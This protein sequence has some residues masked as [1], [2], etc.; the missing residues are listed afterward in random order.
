LTSGSVRQGIAMW[1]KVVAPAILVSVLW[2]AGSSITNYYI[3][4]VYESHAGVLAEN[5]T[6]I[7]AGWA[8]QDALWRLQAVVMEATGKDRR[9]TRLEAD[10][11]ESAFQRHLDE[12][13]KTSFTPEEQ[14]LVKAVREHFAVYGDQIEAALQPPGLAG[15]LTAQ[16]GEKEKTIRL[17]RAVAEPCRQLIDLNE[18][19][20]ADSTERSARVSTV[21]NVVRLA[22]LISGPI[23]GVLWGL[24][25]ARGLRRSISEISVT[26]KDATGV[27][28]RELGSVE[29]RTL[30]DFPALQQQVRTV[31]EQ[32]RRVVDELQQSR[33]RAMLARRRPG[34]RMARPS[35]RSRCRWQSGRLPAWRPRFKGCWILPG[36]RNCTACST[37][38]VRP[39][40]VP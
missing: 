18:R 39:C 12:A 4:R 22:F 23:V 8:M 37:I 6:T 2:I 35:R 19:I 34:G 36:P 25:V 5:V 13:E 26:L 7:R 31:A 38:S 15:L 11:L 27:L 10:E 1:K 20:L 21:V 9:E 14:L 33:R 17:A 3:Q 30:D 29:V 16:T 28:D 32:I 40:G 24:W